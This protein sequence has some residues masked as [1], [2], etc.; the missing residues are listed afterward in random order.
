MYTIEQSAEIT[1]PVATLRRALGTLAGFRGWFAEDTTVD[2]AG[3][4]TFSFAQPEET[5]AVTFTL[6]R[7]DDRGIA[8]TCVHERNNPDWLGT[9]LVVEL[10]PLAEGKTRAVLTHSGYPT[11][12]ECYARCVDAWAHFLGSLAKFATTGAG[13]PFPAQSTL[14]KAAS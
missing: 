9:E 3:R 7:A 2:A 13:A 1:A 10:T 14:Q 12:N 6:D 4:F 8:M 11:K 5:R